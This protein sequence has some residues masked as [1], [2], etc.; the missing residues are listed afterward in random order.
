MA[1]LRLT[2]HALHN[3]SLP[4]AIVVAHLRVCG[5]VPQLLK[6]DVAWWGAGFV[7][8]LKVLAA[9]KKRFTGVGLVDSCVEHVAGEPNQSFGIG[10]LRIGI[11]FL[12]A[13]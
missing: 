2:V 8:I 7:A 13:L 10:V 5:R 6:L 12:L 3:A 9:V 4:I 11:F 1:A